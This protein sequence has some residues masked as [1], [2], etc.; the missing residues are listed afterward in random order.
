M[1]FDFF[2][3]PYPTDALEPVMSKDTVETHYNKHHKGYYNKLANMI[4]DTSMEDKSLLEIIRGTSNPFIYNNAAQVYNHD[5]FWQSLT[6]N[7]EDRKVGE[8]LEGVITTIWGG[9]N[10]MKEVF[11]D[12]GVRRFGSGWIWLVDRGYSIDWVTTSNADTPID[13]YYKGTPLLVVDLWEHAYYLDYKNEREK[14]L[15]KVFDLLNWSFAE[16]NYIASQN[17]RNRRN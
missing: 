4:D 9:M 14:Y 12:R 16:K 7:E 13:D 8:V 17:E 2:K 11:V 5:F 10:Q 1:K 15:K 3:L 6:P